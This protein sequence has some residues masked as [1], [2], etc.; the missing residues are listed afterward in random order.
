MHKEYKS[1]NIKN[2]LTIVIPAKNEAKLLPILL[3]SLEQQDYPQITGTRVLVADA[4]STDGT[5]EIAVHTSDYLNVQVT[6]GGL[7]AAG[8]NAGARSARTPYVLFL[9]ADVELRD[10]TLL[11]RAMEVMKG[12]RLHCVTTNIWC[13]DGTWRDK[14]LYFWNNVAQHC[15]RLVRPF[16][17]GMFMLFDRAKFIE[18]GG[19]NEKALYAEDYLL[20][21]KVERS[22]FGIVSGHLHTTN[23]RFQKMGHSK[24]AGMF[25]RTALNSW[26][27]SYFLRD[28]RY[29]G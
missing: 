1:M 26:N 25:L 21:Q 12:R 28:Q 13:E 8:R 14:T 16:S 15:S 11:R 5:P 17:T 24:I 7:P 18:L 6:P 19:F 3:R 20:S 2:D 22:R 23:R 4:A 10:R 9:D 27:E 29:W